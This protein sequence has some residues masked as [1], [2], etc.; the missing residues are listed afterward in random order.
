MRFLELS[1][2]AAVMGFFA[3]PRLAFV[4]H[5]HDSNS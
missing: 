3:I 4:S 2:N 1:D 5:P